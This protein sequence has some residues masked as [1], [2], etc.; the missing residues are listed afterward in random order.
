LTLYLIE[1]IIGVFALDEE[2]VI[3][4]SFQYPKDSKTIAKIIG[5][6]REGNTGYISDLVSELETAETI[7]SSNIRLVDSLSETLNIKLGDTM[8]ASNKF[9]SNLPELAVELGL[10]DVPEEYYVLNY[11]VSKALAHDDVHEALSGR[12]VLLV[13]A[14]QLLTELDVVLN[15]LSSRMREW[16]GVHFPEMGRRVRSHEDYSGIVSKLGMRENITADAL[17]K[18]TLK[19]KDAVRIEAAV[20]DSMGATLEELDINIVQNYANRTL[21]M[22]KFR[23]ELSEYI[24]IITAEVAPNVSYLAGPILTA[25]LIE[26]AGGLKRLAMI[27]AST[28]Q[29]LGAEKA[30]YRAKKTNAKGPKH[31]LLFQHSYVNSSPRDIRGRRARGLAAK[32]A[33][34]AR[35]DLFSGAFIAEGL[36]DQLA[37]FNSVLTTESE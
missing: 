37:D 14:V 16:Y 35:A 34:A 31:G 6:L 26:K 36:A 7:I 11:T 25:K 15:G 4:A 1:T 28:I 23:E 30:L 24:S 2:N 8:K 3:Q 33:I 5:K 21:D 17:M 32:I 18:M 12:E 19:K 27:P 9:K 13:P 29:V 20:E 10:I 22:Y